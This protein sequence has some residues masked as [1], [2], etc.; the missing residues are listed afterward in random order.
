MEA[1]GQLTGGDAQDFNNLVQVIMG[2]LETLRRNLP[3]EAGRLVRATQNAMA[4]A[5]CAALTQ[6]LLAFSRRQ[7]LNP[8]PIDVNQMVGG[9]SDLLN[10][11]LGEAI[12]IELVRGSGGC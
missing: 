7:P 1:V 2:N 9:L 8:K 10:R 3:D 12:A 4:G 6:R 11:T 5:K